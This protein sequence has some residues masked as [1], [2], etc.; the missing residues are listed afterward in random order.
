MTVLAWIL[1]IVYIK[2]RLAAHKENAYK[3]EMRRE[4]E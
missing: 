2:V 4:P 1:Q 3:E